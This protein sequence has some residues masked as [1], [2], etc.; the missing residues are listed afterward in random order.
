MGG[1]AVGPLVIDEQHTARATHGQATDMRR[2]TESF[3]MCYS[4]EKDDGN[5]CVIHEA[6]GRAFPVP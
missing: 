1:S 5:Q 6:G 4:R 2:E 3:F